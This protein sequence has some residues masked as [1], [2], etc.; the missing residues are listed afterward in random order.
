MPRF[1]G[2][3]D[4]MF[5]FTTDHFEVWAGVSKAD[6][7]HERK[8]FPLS[9][10]QKYCPVLRGGHARRT[11]RRYFQTLKGRIDCGVVWIRTKQTQRVVIIHLS[12]SYEVKLM[13]FV[14]ATT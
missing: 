9:S 8:P 6:A 5:D 13:I 7:T 10:S 3:S 2:I 11:L 14:D 1:A 12:G 4:F